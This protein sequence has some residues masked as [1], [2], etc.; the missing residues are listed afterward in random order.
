MEAAFFVDG[1][2]ISSKLFQMPSTGYYF[3]LDLDNFFS[4]APG[5]HTLDVRLRGLT[6]AIPTFPCSATHKMPTPSVCC[7]IRPS[8]AGIPSVDAVAQQTLGPI[9]GGNFVGGP[10]FTLADA[11]AASPD[12][13]TTFTVADAAEVYHAS[14]LLA[15]YNSNNGTAFGME[16]AF[17]VDGTQVSSQLFQAYSKGF[18]FRVDLDSYLSL[19]PGSHTLD[20]R[21]RG[22]NGGNIYISVLSDVPKQ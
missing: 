21:L 18:Y 14:A 5:S 1:A 7:A 6:V 17:F 12:L 20:V 2:Q 8:A 16:A 9:S 11:G 3:R 19:A 10:T 15:F 4:L 13:S 22:L